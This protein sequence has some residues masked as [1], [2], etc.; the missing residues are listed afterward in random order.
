[1][2][3]TFFFTKM[4]SLLLLLSG[5]CSIAIAQTSISLN[6]QLT[7]QATEK[8]ITI[9]PNKQVKTLSFTSASFE[10]PTH[11]LP[12][13]AKKVKLNN[14]GKL[15]VKLL[16]PIYELVDLPNDLEINDFIK[17]DI[18]IDAQ[19]AYEKKHPFA[20]IEFIPIRLNP[21]TQQYEKLIQFDLLVETNATN[22]A[23]PKGNRSYTKTSVLNQ[24]NFYKFKV[25]QTGIH[26][27][28][29]AFLEALGIS[30]EVDINKTRIYGNG[31]GMLPELAG[32]DKYD[33]LVEN[34]VEIHDQ[35]N[36]GVFDGDDYILFYAQSP[37][38]W[39]YNSDSLY[40]EHSK[41]L[42]D[43]HNHYFLNFDMGTSKRIANQGNAS[44]ATITVNSFDDYAFHE[45]ELKSL[46][47]TG[48]VWYGE[49]FN[50]ILS[51]DF[52]FSFPN[53][54]TNTP[55]TIAS[56][57][58]ARSIS[59]PDS[60]NPSSFEVSING[61]LEQIHNLASVEV[62]YENRYATASFE[63]D[64]ATIN[65]DNLNV[66]FTY[67]RNN[68]SA[69]GWLDYVAIQCRR[70]LIFTGSQ[71]TFRDI[72][73]VGEGQVAE[74]EIGNANNIQIWEVS[75]IGDVKKV[76]LNAGKF[77]ANTSSLQEYIAFNGDEFF[78]PEAVGI[79][80][81]QNL[82]EEE[83]PDMIIVTI[84]D[85][86][87]PA[88][89]LADLHR[90]LDDL[91]VKVVT[92]EQIYNEFSS[93]NQDI[94]AI[95]DYVKM[96]Y[97]RAGMDTEKAPQYLLLLGDASYDY[98]HIDKNISNQNIVPGFE[99]YASINTLS[100]YCSDDYFAVLDD[101]E[102]EAMDTKEQFL[103]VGIGRIP[104]KTSEEA[105]IV[106]DK[107]KHYVSNETLGE[108]RNQITF[109]ADDED[110]NTHFNDAESHSGY[111]RN[112]YEEYNID[113][114]YLDAYQQVSTAGG[115]RYPD[116]NQ[117]INEKIFAGTFVMNY[118]GHG[119]ENGWAEERIL[120][121]TDIYKWNNRDQLPLFITATCSFSRY[122][123]PE[124]TSAGE[125]L[126]LYENGGAI[127]LMTTV[128]LVYSNANK[129]MNSAF[130]N[131]LFNPVNGE[132]PALGEIARL[133]KNEVDNTSDAV[134]N[135]KFTLLGDPALRLNYPK[136][137]I[138][139]TTINQQ[140][141]SGLPDTIKALSKVKVT[142]EVRRNGSKM[143]DFNGA[144]YPTVFDKMVNVKTLQND[145]GSNPGNFDLLK[146][147]VFKGQATVTN[148]SFEFSFIVP[149]DISYQFGQGR[150]SFYAENG[151]I[152]ANGFT[153][154]L[155]IGG[156][157]EN[158]AADD[159]G[160]KVD[161]YMNDDKFVF[162]GMTDA[163]PVLVIQL[164]DESGI[165]TVGNGIGHDITSVI[166]EENNNLYV[167][168]Q[169]Y[170]ATLD[171]Y[172]EGEVRYPLSDLEPGL[173]TISAKAWDVHNNSG[174]GYTEFIVAESADIALDNVLNYPNP[175]TD[176]TAF[177]FEH[178]RPGD[179]L[180]VTVRIMAL[181]G[182]VIKTLQERLV[183]DG[184]RVDNITWDGLD[185]F[186]DKIG[187]GTYIYQVTVQ[188]SA[189]N[190][191]KAIQKLVVLK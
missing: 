73:S 21:N 43:T 169:Y 36:N 93:G 148:G 108:W 59:G 40:Y 90:E 101:T 116:V 162:G 100:S 16:N 113:K 107:I 123:N 118:V 158:V 65:S 180:L 99:S 133:A 13:Y 80:V 66:N 31:G 97:D 119:G 94:S 64:N 149:K 189:N 69:I 24:G 5:I 154:N 132:I 109:I 9:T 120:N 2:N 104:A 184:F 81:N 181:S 137:D 28:E 47:K 115:S 182:K 87:T 82:H 102:G 12:V 163:D 98:K 185:E 95:R 72:E 70:N 164:Y 147:V 166:D 103:D 61:N 171:S 151:T 75:N 77:T 25:N 29:A 175:F 105:Q 1:M 125:E 89:E 114:I 14:D 170:K 26:K 112:N 190:T 37:D 122:D 8:V 45:A 124:K 20:I 86:L 4:L 54:D 179:E 144:V 17:N 156:I 7:W 145:G 117:S 153:E 55:V 68:S 155:V 165:N 48:R 22:S 71:M 176:N 60:S 52:S 51:Q 178:N 62:G 91:E 191:A 161:I 187:R 63:M 76:N 88:E 131:H 152:D 188:D 6:E 57:V 143:N 183:S 3:K 136:Y 50:A 126:L 85:F 172:Q 38:H 30:E 160:P 44:G 128:R 174:T 33:D 167:L 92:V 141:I 78:S 27:I 142:G 39:R 157:A 34:P 168:N 129:D 138:V 135:R 23:K 150:I 139:A 127:A 130:L 58:A 18:A 67:R 83:Y 49:E 140:D 35:N 159:E 42:Y 32:A 111:L 79:I 84:P 110:G 46:S 10:Y 177:W 15:K 11:F 74:F 134:N 41:H 106:V 53:L 56:R 19:I 173:H 146:N 96:Y 186:G 121:T